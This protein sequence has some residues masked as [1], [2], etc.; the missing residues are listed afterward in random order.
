MIALAWAAKM[1]P[2]FA[3]VLAGYLYDGVLEGWGG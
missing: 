2:H 3:L 1:K